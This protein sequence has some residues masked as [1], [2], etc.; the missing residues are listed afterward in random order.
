MSSEDV[1][2][3]PNPAHHSVLLIGGLGGSILYARN[4]ATN[5]TE[6]VW[7]KLINTNSVMMKNL[8]GYVDPVTF[9]YKPMDPNIEIFAPDDN[10]GLFAIDYLVPDLPISSRYRSYYHS[11]IRFFKYHGYVPGESLFGYPY[12]WRQTYD[13]ERL[14]TGLINRIEEAFHACGDKKIDI[15]THSQ[16]G[17]LV[18][19]M[20]QLHPDILSKYVRRWIALACPFNGATRTL[21]AMLFGYNFGL[22]T[23]VFSP[24]IMKTL[25][26]QMS[27]AFW[28]IPPRSFPASP[29]L[30]V[31]YRNKEE[32]TWYSF[33]TDRN[34]HCYDYDSVPLEGTGRAEKAKSESAENEETTKDIRDIRPNDTRFIGGTPQHAEQ[35]ACGESHFTS[36]DHHKSTRFSPSF[37]ATRSNPEMVNMESQPS[38]TEAVFS[39]STKK[40]MLTGFEYLSHASFTPSPLHSTFVKGCP[41]PTHVQSNYRR[42]KEVETGEKANPLNT[43]L[44]NTLRWGGQPHF[45][46]FEEV[47]VLPYLGEE[48]VFAQLKEGVGELEDGDGMITSEIETQKSALNLAFKRM[49]DILEGGEEGGLGE[50]VDPRVVGE[51]EGRIE[52]EIEAKE[53][54]GNLVEE[55]ESPDEEKLKKKGWTLRKT[56]EGLIAKF[57]EAKENSQK[58]KDA[59]NEMKRASLSPSTSPTPHTH[60]ASLSTHSQHA[61]PTSLSS[62]SPVASNQPVP[63]NTNSAQ[64]VHKTPSPTTAESD[65]EQPLNPESIQLVL[66]SD[67]LPQPTAFQTPSPLSVPPTAAKSA[68]PAPTSPSSS[69]IPLATNPTPK[70]DPL[71]SFVT[72][73]TTP[74][75]TTPF[76]DY[77]GMIDSKE[78]VSSRVDKIVDTRIL[79]PSFEQNNLYELIQRL[80]DNKPWQNPTPAQI[81]A[82][83]NA[84]RELPVVFPPQDEFEFINIFGTGN[85]TTWHLLV[86]DNERS[87]NNNDAIATELDLN[88]EAAKAN[89]VWAVVDGDCSVPVVSAAN[90]GM[91]ASARFEVRNCTHMGLVFDHR[92]LN[93]VAALI[94]LPLP[95]ATTVSREGDL[96]EVKQKEGPFVEGKEENTGPQ[97][98]TFSMQ[99]GKD[100]RGLGKQEEEMAGIEGLGRQTPVAG[101]E[102]NE[103][104]VIGEGERGS[105]DRTQTQAEV[106]Y[107]H[108]G[109]RESFS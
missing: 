58:S 45:H 26:T 56:L 42:K 102:L 64:D 92:V 105:P 70:T 86:L 81:E 61:T 89:A 25:Q 46:S 14:Q 94:G 49:V 38:S 28:F 39:I 68:P 5:Q 35:C 103:E 19:T 15:I 82:H 18:R 63:N 85:A 30:C 7:P 57:G 8:S 84:I 48:E 34:G 72:W 13:L 32:F 2:L 47:G 54:E 97:I 76:D 22:P 12:D 37:A 100:L 4:K 44:Q 91:R 40:Y 59:K 90:D 104:W 60:P 10:Y 16:G 50:A 67:K 62:Q 107:S 78:V 11:F 101:L 83:V 79:R 71:S 1:I 93:L 41:L 80:N 98:K 95:F 77:F 55:R 17:L 9:E 23:F 74:R 66:L 51:R 108:I 33:H 99:L 53:K 87:K 43:I 27:L 29:K 73:L 96:V 21:C 31:K 75:A 65:S 6:L 69:P 52:G 20:I 24:T 109:R 3:K 88:K 106:F 36:A